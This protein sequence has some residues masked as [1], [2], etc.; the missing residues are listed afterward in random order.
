M[1]NYI[2]RPQLKK[3]GQRVEERSLAALLAGFVRED[4]EMATVKGGLEELLGGCMAASKHA[5]HHR[6]PERAI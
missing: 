5:K 1:L 2:L 6:V 3:R 4:L